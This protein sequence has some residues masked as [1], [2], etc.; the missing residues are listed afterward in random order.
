MWAVIQEHERAAAERAGR[1]EAERVLAEAEARIVALEARVRRAEGRV[2][3]FIKRQQP[4]PAGSPGA[5]PVEIST[6]P[7]TT[8]AAEARLI[9]LEA[10]LAGLDEKAGGRILAI[11]RRLDAHSTALALQV[12]RIKILEAD[13]MTEAKS[14][15]G[16]ARA[17]LSAAA[18][19]ADPPAERH[20]AARH[21]E[22]TA[23]I[24]R[25]KGSAAV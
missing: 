3:F 8:D 7:S 9:A 24:A 5:P 13:A 12:G 22:A 4:T 25:L 14:I 20:A 19:A 10:R 18:Y 17:S 16:L 1:A 6:P 21:E 23:R 2:E 11:E 15:E